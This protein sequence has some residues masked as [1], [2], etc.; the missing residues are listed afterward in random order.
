[1]QARDG[2]Y[3][4][5]QP[6]GSL[7]GRFLNGRYEILGL[8]GRGGMASV[9]R[10]RDRV[11]GRI[12]ALKL[13]HPHFAEDDDFVQRFQREAEFAASLSGHPNIVSIFDVGRDG[14]SRYIVMEMI[15]GRNLKEVVRAEAPL[16]IGRALIIGEEIAAALHFA[17]QRGLVH[18][19][20]KP[21]NILL[22]DDR[23]KVTDFGI[24][25]N[26]TTTPMTRAGIVMG[27]THYLSP[28]QVR[29][30]RSDARSDIYAL[31]VV[32]YEMLT[33]RV[34]FDGDDRFVVAMRHVTDEPVPP[35]DLDPDVPASVEAVVLKALRKNPDARFGTAG[36][37]GDAIRRAAMRDERA[38][39]VPLLLSPA[40]GRDTSAGA[41]IALHRPPVPERTGRS[42]G[43][44]LRRRRRIPLLVIGAGLLAILAAGGTAA[45]RARIGGAMR[46]L[47]T[48][49]GAIGSSI[50]HRFLGRATTTSCTGQAVTGLALKGFYA[51]EIAV[52]PGQS[53]TLDYTVDNATGACERLYLGATL[54]SDTIAGTVLSDPAGARIVQARPGV[55]VYHR[56][57][58]L[59]VQA[60]GQSFDLQV[61]VSLAGGPRIA[62]SAVIPHLI[63]VSS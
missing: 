34:P 42:S 11:L 36:E 13:L 10:A 50:P 12:V 56:R 35:R 61:T 7:A 26:A 19:D 58:L 53:I 47:H 40:N 17:H 63:T 57:F 43:L 21:Q 8:A 49:P 32:L 41:T 55:A 22:P 4:S 1:M 38:S 52:R 15:E 62:T 25:W 59:P 54:S 3:I 48:L 37:F 20:V 14:N 27:T 51:E 31:G 9:Y 39:P 45:E 28:E 33:G 44:S 23:I 46:A 16:P 29:G 5:G 18:R 2:E 60:R 30:G 6:A 24:A